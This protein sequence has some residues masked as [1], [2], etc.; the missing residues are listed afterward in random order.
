[1]AISGLHDNFA[2]RVRA[3]AACGKHVIVYNTRSVTPC[4]LGYSPA[5]RKSLIDAYVSIRL[6]R[7]YWQNIDLTD[8]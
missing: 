8:V 2:S 5:G 3:L 7:R 4:M 1:M 6:L